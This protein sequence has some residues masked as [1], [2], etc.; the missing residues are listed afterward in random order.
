MILFNKK[1]NLLY[2]LVFYWIWTFTCLISILLNRNASSK[3]KN[4]C[5]TTLRVMGIR[6]GTINL[7]T[8]KA[9]N[10]HN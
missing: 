2:S 8:K 7:K 6:D 1:R 9:A 5:A 10:S 4:N 3:R